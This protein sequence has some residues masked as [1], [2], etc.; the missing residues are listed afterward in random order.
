M[1][2]T[3]KLKGV[4]WIIYFINMIIIIFLSASIYKTSYQICEDF[5]AR[6]FLEEAKYLPKVPSKVLIYT[7]CL[8]LCIGLSNFIISCVHKKKKWITMV[9]LSINIIQCIYI[10]YYVN[11]SYKGL[12]L[13]LVASIFIYV[14]WSLGKFF[15]LGVTLMSFIMLDYDLLSV[16]VNLISF[17]NYANYHSE[18]IRMYLYGM[19]TTLTSLNDIFFFLFFFLLLQS[20]ISENKQYIW[21]NDKLKEKADELEI[22]NEKLEDYAKES[23]QVAKMK[24][25]NRLAREIHDILGHSLT[26]ITTGLEASI[27]LL[28]V[29]FGAAQ[30]QL[31]KIQEIAKKGLIDV[32]RSVRELKIDTIE[33]Y[34]FIPAIEKLIGE[35]NALSTTYVKLTIEGETLKLSDDEEQMVYRVVQ[36]SL[37]NAMRHGRAQNA[38]VH[39]RFH[40]YEINIRIQDD[41]QGCKDISKGFGLTHIEERAEILGGTVEFISEVDGG[42]TTILNIPI[43]WGKAYD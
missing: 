19:K 26:S 27:Q 40:Y 17:Q 7:I 9:L 8:I 28:E 15:L 4:H 29:N 36:E 24:E 10:T 20:K 35:I 2:K 3:I 1:N 11:Y 13:F 41:G 33:K 42:F 39:I 14:Q 43:R 34:A 16:K 38:E 22:A 32:R 31:L 25:R 30:R 21:L 37:T 18:Y 5:Q 6:M 23:I 12:F